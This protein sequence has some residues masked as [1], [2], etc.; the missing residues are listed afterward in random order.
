MWYFYLIQ[1]EYN[2]LSSIFRCGK[3]SIDF[4]IISKKTKKNILRL[5]LFMLNEIKLKQDNN[6]N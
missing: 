1:N 4:D 5:I 2:F 3:Q 6:K